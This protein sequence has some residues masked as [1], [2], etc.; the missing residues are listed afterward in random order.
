MN[1]GQELEREETLYLFLQYVLFVVVPVTA[2][3]TCLHFYALLRHLCVTFSIEGQWLRSQKW[4]NQNFSDHSDI[5][6]VTVKD[7]I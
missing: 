6:L 1:L 7:N 5:V 2:Q 3:I 4:R